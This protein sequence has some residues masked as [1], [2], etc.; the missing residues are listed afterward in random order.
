[1]SWIALD[2]LVDA[3]LFCLENNSM[4][5][6]VN[7][8]APQPVTN[9]EFTKAL[10]RVLHRPTFLPVPSIALKM[11]PGNMAKEI[12]LTSARVEPAKLQRA[13][14]KFQYSDID[15]ALADMTG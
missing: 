14:F 7:V 6:P 10:G 9:L 1:V 8:T 4:S 13:G 5:G 11:L 3:I 2:D 12:L 15:D